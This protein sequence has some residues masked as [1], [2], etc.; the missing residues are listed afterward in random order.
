MMTRS[1]VENNALRSAGHC[2][3]VVGKQKYADQQ[4]AR[5]KN[6]YGAYK[7]LTTRPV[8]PNLLDGQN[9]VR[10]QRLVS[11]LSG[12]SCVQWTPAEGPSVR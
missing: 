5:G 7:S 3:L 4:N 10:N 8:E 9:L 11:A 6:I 1:T 2:S 12:V